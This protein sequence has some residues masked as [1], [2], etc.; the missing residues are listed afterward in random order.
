[1]EEKLIAQIDDDKIKYA[2]F[3]K[4][5]KM[6][7]KLEIGMTE[8][9]VKYVLGTP[10]IMDTFNANRWDYYTSVSQGKKIYTEGKVTLFF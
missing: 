9:Q 5:E 10:L 6:F 7:E 2:V 1:M 8:S 4:D 3:Q